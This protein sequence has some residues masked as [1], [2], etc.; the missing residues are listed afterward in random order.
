MALGWALVG[1]FRSG[2]D[3]EVAL[4][5]VGAVAIL[6][7]VVAF[8]KRPQSEVRHHGSHAR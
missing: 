3:D 8:A 5:A 1:G 7:G 4:P 6:M 2:V